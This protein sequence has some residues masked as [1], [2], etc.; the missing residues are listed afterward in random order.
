M[1]EVRNRVYVMKS[2]TLTRLIITGK[3]TCNR[4]GLQFKVGDRVTG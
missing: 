4:C 3:A 2:G 1:K